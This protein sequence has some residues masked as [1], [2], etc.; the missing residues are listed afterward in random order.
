MYLTLTST[1]SSLPSIPEMIGMIVGRGGVQS[2]MKHTL[3]SSPLIRP[4]IFSLQWVPQHSSDSFYPLLA[5]HVLFER[6]DENQLWNGFEYISAKEIRVFCANYKGCIILEVPCSIHSP[7]VVRQGGYS[8]L[9]CIILITK[10]SKS[11][12]R[13][14]ALLK[15]E[16]NTK[17][18]GGCRS[19]T[20]RGT[21]VA[22][23]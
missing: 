23:F 19:P 7:Q 12:L 21:E 13:F 5:L 4:Q 1:S 2:S 16:C 3:S 22:L 14:Q 8:Y 15:K 18:V 10:T 17:L 20:L 6:C 9:E 11:A